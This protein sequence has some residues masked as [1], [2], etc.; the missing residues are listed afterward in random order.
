MPLEKQEANASERVW[1]YISEWILGRF[2]NFAAYD[3]GTGRIGYS[4]AFTT[5]ARPLDG[6]TAQVDKVGID[7]GEAALFRHSTALVI[8]TVLKMDGA[9]GAGHHPGIPRFARIRLQFAQGGVR[10]PPGI[11]GSS[12]GVEVGPRRVQRHD[13]VGHLY[14]H[15]PEAADRRSDC[16]RSQIRWHRFET[17]L[18]DPELVAGVPRANSQGRTSARSRRR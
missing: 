1:R 9:R 10:P 16:L 11:A 14:L 6:I 8:N 2:T 5:Y 18:Q 12:H 15:E 17:G 4:K 13:H 7:L 3:A